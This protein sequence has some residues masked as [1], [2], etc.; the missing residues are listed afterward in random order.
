[1]FAD[2]TKMWRVIKDEEDK[3]TPEFDHDKLMEWF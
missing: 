1:M 2:D 3:E